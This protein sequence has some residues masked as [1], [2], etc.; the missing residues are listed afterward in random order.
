MIYGVATRYGQSTVWGDLA[1]V[2]KEQAE[3]YAEIWQTSL[4]DGAETFVTPNNIGS[5]SQLWDK[6][7][8]FDIVV[9]YLAELD[10]YYLYVM[11]DN[12]IMGLKKEAGKVPLVCELYPNIRSILIGPNRKTQEISIR[13]KA[14]N[15]KEAIKQFDDLME[16]VLDKTD[17]E[18]YSL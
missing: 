8:P 15:K 14:W 7:T 13:L 12:E 9:C 6:N 5:A 4:F 3:A 18:A 1:F 17:P 16:E 11:T 2:S 10:K